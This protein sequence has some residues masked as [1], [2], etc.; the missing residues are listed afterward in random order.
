MVGLDPVTKNCALGMGNPTC[1]RSCG[2]PLVLRERTPPLRNMPRGAP[3]QVGSRWLVTV[4]SVRKQ[5][6][7]SLSGVSGQLQRLK[8]R[9]RVAGPR[10]QGWGLLPACARISALATAHRAVPARAPSARASASVTVVLPEMSPHWMRSLTWAF[11]SPCS[12]EPLHVR[13]ILAQ[14]SAAPF[15]QCRWLPSG[16]NSG[17]LNGVAGRGACLCKPPSRHPPWPK[18]TS[19]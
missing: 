18:E 6:R 16:G 3:G 13:S 19:S 4:A 9:T 8:T 11:I 10:R 7:W 2:P 15:L 17:F 5:D 1:P 14:D 12:V